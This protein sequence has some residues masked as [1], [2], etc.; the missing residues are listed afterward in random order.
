MKHFHITRF[1]DSSEADLGN[2]KSPI[3]TLINICEENESFLANIKCGLAMS[4]K[5]VVRNV[6]PSLPL[7][8]STF[9]SC[10]GISNVLI[11]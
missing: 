3:P 6:F 5:I 10:L 7:S 1:T 9:P 11:Q 4:G 8:F 2:F